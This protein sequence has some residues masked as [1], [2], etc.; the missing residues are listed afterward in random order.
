MRI[1]ATPLTSGRVTP[2]L[3]TI[4]G[5]YRWRGLPG[6]TPNDARYREPGGDR[7]LAGCAERTARREARI[8]EFATVLAALGY[9]DPATASPAAVLEAGR[10][11]GVAAKTART[12]RATLKQQREQE[13]AP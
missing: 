13:A 1:Q 3:E 2:G 6:W 9:P 11:V 10:R 12:Y 5:G 8:A 7:P 4:S